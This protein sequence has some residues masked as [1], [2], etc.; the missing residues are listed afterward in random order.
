M[1]TQIKVHNISEEVFEQIKAAIETGKLKP[2]SKLPA[3]RELVKH[4]GVSRVP[5]REALRLLANVG[6]IE[7]RQGGGS[8]VCSMLNN[9]LR[10][11]LDLLIKDNT[12]KLFELVEVR[13]EIET[14]AAYY[15]ASNATQEQVAQLGDIIDEMRRHFDK[16]EMAPDSLDMRFHLVIAQ[17]SSNTIR[18]HLLHTI[19][20]LFS[21]YLR[22]TI[23][24]ICRD[25]KSQQRLFEQHVQIYESV[26]RHDPERARNAVD[27]HLTFVCDALRKQMLPK[28]DNLVLEEQ[29]V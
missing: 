28:R 24:T 8:Y 18:A 7:T 12:E 17:A 21:D 3:E 14:W 9:R 29:A 19:Q 16:N 22:V 26:R 11:P 4:L 10:D 25:R 1:F 27:E 2:G 20:R 23:E 13:K 6:L 15:A 5:I